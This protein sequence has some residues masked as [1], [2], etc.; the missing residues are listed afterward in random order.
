MDL[1]PCRLLFSPLTSVEVFLR[2][3]LRL[4]LLLHRYCSSRTHPI[5]SVA[6]S[7]KKRLH[8]LRTPLRCW[9]PQR[10]IYRSKTL[11]THTRPQIA[12][13]INRSPLNPLANGRRMGHL[14]GHQQL[15]RLLDPPFHIHFLRSL[16]P[17]HHLRYPRSQPLLPDQPFSW[18]CWRSRHP[19]ITCPDVLPCG[20][21]IRSQHCRHHL[22]PTRYRQN[23]THVNAFDAS[24]EIRHIDVEN[25]LVMDVALVD[26]TRHVPTLH[27][28]YLTLNIITAFP[29]HAAECGSSPHP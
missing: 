6:S 24:T 13:F 5:S 1:R 28:P 11:S 14:E 9:I 23:E 19:I 18:L 21:C 10:C 15:L 17:R 22:S 2:L 12:I 7:K 27:A 25:A 3:R 16:I 29:T 4:A 26:C 8:R 20:S